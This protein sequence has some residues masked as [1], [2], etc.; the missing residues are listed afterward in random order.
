MPFCSNGTFDQLPVRF[1]RE[2]DV[3]FLPDSCR[4]ANSDVFIGIALEVQ[5][6]DAWR[7][8]AE[9]GEAALMVSVDEFFGG[10]RR[11][12]KNTEPAEGI[13]ALVRR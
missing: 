3:Q 1:A 13:H 2:P 9:Q 10:R 6:A 5:P 11:F 12:G 4:P 7:T 8:H